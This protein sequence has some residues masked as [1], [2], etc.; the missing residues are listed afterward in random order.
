VH[1]FDPFGALTPETEINVSAFK[2][3]FVAKSKINFAFLSFC[4]GFSSIGAMHRT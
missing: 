3:F 4:D 2:Q 1:R